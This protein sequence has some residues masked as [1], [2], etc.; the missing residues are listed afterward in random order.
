MYHADKTNSDEIIN[1][2]STAPGTRFVACGL[3]FE[4]EEDRVLSPDKSIDI[5]GTWN[6][7]SSWFFRKQNHE[8]Q[9]NNTAIRLAI[10]LALGKVKTVTDCADP[11]GAYYFP[12]FNGSRDV[13]RLEENYLPA[14]KRY[15]AGGGTL[16]A[17]QQTLYDDVIAMMNS[18]VNDR[19]ADD[20]LIGQF[21]DM[22][23]E[24]GIYET[25]EEKESSFDSFF[26]RT[27]KKSNDITY[28]LFGAKGFLDC[29]VS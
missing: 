6:R 17:E 14:L 7:D 15:L 29:P 8:L 13:S 21:Y 11:D 18:N 5:A 1:I 9:G 19:E 2:D 3:Q 4:D 12:Q 20:A 10:N 26:T 23:V 24:L 28:S 16:T 27:L 25:K 22:L